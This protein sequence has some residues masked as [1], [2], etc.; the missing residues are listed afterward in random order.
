MTLTNKDKILLGLLA[1]ILFVGMMYVYGIMPTNDEVKKL[2]AQ[3]QTKQDEL[4]DL[5]MQIASINISAVNK[6]Y[7]KLLDYYYT[8]DKG[9]LADKIGI[10]AV[11]RMIIE[12][13]DAHNIEGYT[14]AGWKIS[15]DRFTSSYGDYKA[16][17][18]VASAN[19]PTT[20][21]VQDCNDLYAFIDT[22]NAN[23]FFKMDSLSI[24]YEE[25]EV[26]GQPPTAEGSFVLLY[27]MRAKQGQAEVPALLPAVE[28]VSADGAKVQFG[29][30]TDA[31]KYEF[32]I[33]TETDGERAYKLIEN[34]ELKASG[35]DGLEKTFTATMLGGK[36]TYKIGVRAVGDKIKGYFKSMLDDTMTAVEITV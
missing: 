23:K 29:A 9:E 2:E 24:A 28:N 22:V 16:D 18:F 15:E 33:I 6:E 3:V 31:E 21:T 5:Q 34:V 26:E 32:Y 36:G 17:Y 7:D 27:Y 11:N 20:F 8:T 13:L 14:T 30:V 10:I 25:N 1:V 19:C 12:M 35:Q 4:R